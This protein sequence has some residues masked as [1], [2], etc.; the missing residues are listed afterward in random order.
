MLVPSSLNN[1]PISRHKFDYEM[2]LWNNLLYEKSLQRPNRDG[3]VAAGDTIFSIIGRPSHIKV[4]DTVF[5]VISKS[6]TRVLKDIEKRYQNIL[7]IDQ[8]VDPEGSRGIKVCIPVFIIYLI[9]RHYP[10]QLARLLESLNLS[11]E[12]SPNVQNGVWKI[13]GGDFKS[14]GEKAEEL[15]CWIPKLLSMTVNSIVIY[16][17]AKF[18]KTACI[19]I[20][21]F[22]ARKRK[23]LTVRNSVLIICLGN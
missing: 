5:T 9:D 4:G 6:W 13:H 23:E 2:I 22:V 10:A 3:F 21:D 11:V 12:F 20:L 17:G 8:L 18:D 7:T 14:Q 1:E 19:I 16:P 15:D